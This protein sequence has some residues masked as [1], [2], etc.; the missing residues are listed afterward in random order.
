[1]STTLQREPST[2]RGGSAAERWLIALAAAVLV[3]IYLLGKT[4][5][6]L[7]FN[8]VGSG[9]SGSDSLLAVLVGIQI[10]E[11]PA[12]LT[13][14]LQRSVFYLLADL[15]GMGSEVFQAQMIGPQI[16]S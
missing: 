6:R 2:A 14:D 5:P 8:P 4:W 9:N 7:T 1:M 15:F 11:G 16:S 13:H 10:S 12:S 3:G